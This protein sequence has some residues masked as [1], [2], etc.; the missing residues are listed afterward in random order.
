VFLCLLLL[1]CRSWTAEQC[2]NAAYGVCQ[3]TAW[4][5]GQS[6]CGNMFNGAAKCNKDEFTKFYGG[7]FACAQVVGF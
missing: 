2:G 3:S 5:K 4:D 7:E 1:L 6:P